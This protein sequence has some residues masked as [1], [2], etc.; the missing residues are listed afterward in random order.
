VG[1]IAVQPDPVRRREFRQRLAL[2]LLGHVVLLFALAW[3]PGLE[4]SAP[5]GVIAVDLVAAPGAAPAARPAPAQPRPVPAAA[6]KIVLPAEPKAEPKPPAPA[7][8]KPEAKPRVAEPKPEPKPEPA[9][10]AERDYG[11]VLADLRAE[12]GEPVPAA[13]ETRAGAAQPGAGGSGRP[14]SPEVAAWL[15][16]AKVHVRRSWVMPAGFRMQPLV[17]VVEV[18]LDSQGRVIGEPELVRGSGNPWYDENVVRGIRKASPLPPPPEAGEW[19]FQF[20]A[21]EAY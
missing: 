6:R 7:K 14:V 12:V 19:T 16:R 3:S 5:A 2:S 9:P 1:G 15:S 20:D 8:P 11:D 18:E 21:E 4:I 13:E 17:A 10:P